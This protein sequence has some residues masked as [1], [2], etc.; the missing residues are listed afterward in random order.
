MFIRHTVRITL[1]TVFFV[2][3]L[4]ISTDAIC[5]RPEE[6]KTWKRKSLTE[7]AVASDIVVYGEVVSSPCWKPGYVKPTVLPTTVQILSGGNSSNITSNA[8]AST[9]HQEV[10]STTAPTTVPYNCTSEFYSAVIK[11][12][13]VIKGGSVPLFVVLQGFGHGEDVCLDESYHDYHAYN[14]MKYLVFLG[15]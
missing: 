15:R 4:L 9:P 7:R 1:T 5:K 8:T 11:V 10:N 13:C 6:T 14:R 12:I 3:S 2:A